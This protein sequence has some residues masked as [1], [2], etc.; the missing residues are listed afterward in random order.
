MAHPNMT[1]P[2]KDATGMNDKL[3]ETVCPGGTVWDVVVGGVIVKSG[4]ACT[5]S[6]NETCCTTEPAVP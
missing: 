6:G 4:A 5:T 2:E 3:K 1:V